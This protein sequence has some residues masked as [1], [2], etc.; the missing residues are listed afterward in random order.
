MCA[1]FASRSDGFSWCRCQHT[2]ARFARYFDRCV[3]FRSGE[4][5]AVP[6]S[7][8]R[9]RCF[10]LLRHCY[11]RV[12]LYTAVGSILFAPPNN[13]SSNRHS[14]RTVKKFPDTYRLCRWLASGSPVYAVRGGCS[15]GELA[16]GNHPSVAP[17]AV[18]INK[19]ICAGVVRRRSLVWLDFR[20]PQLGLH[21]SPLAV[22]LQLNVQKIHDI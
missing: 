15:I 3:V 14:F 9:C 7:C 5:R 19:S 11:Y 10:S 4:C 21:V 12:A 13:V 16:Y 6:Q 22:R 1:D 20:C 2:H 18:A 17:H 8:C